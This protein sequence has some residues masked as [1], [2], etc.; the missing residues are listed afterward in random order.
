MNDIAK[1]K[2]FYAEVFGWKFTDYGP[3][4]TAVEDGR[5]SGG[6]HLQP[7]ARPAVGNRLVI[8]YAADLA[9]AERAVTAAG[10]V[11]TE[12]HEFPGGRRFRFR[13][14]LGNVLAV[15]TAISQ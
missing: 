13:D 8:M 6:F 4:Y 11:V 1:A 5:L 2:A 14:P 7:E 12:R 9:A 10:G 15:W 3:D